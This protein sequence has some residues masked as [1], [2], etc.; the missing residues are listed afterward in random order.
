[1]GPHR[2]F[3]VQGHV[4]ALGHDLLVAEAKFSSAFDLAGRW[5][6]FFLP[7]SFPLKLTAVLPSSSLCL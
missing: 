6:G 5:A 7:Q 2:T 3:L 1:L 4:A